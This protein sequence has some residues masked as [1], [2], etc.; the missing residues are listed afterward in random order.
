MWCLHPGEMVVM[1]LA[2]L[3]KLTVQIKKLPEQG[4]ICAFMSG[5]SSCFEC[6]LQVSS[7]IDNM[8]LCQLLTNIHIIMTDEKE[9]EEPVVAANGN[10]DDPLPIIIIVS[11]VS[12]TI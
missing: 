1:F 10:L 12:P 3:V 9:S 8:T 5:L 4:M 7:R 6:P 2:E 11:P